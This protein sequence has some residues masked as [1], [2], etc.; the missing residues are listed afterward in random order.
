MAAL[1][2]RLSASADTL[3]ATSF[4]WW[5]PLPDTLPGAG[6]SRAS[7]SGFQTFAGNPP[8]R[9]EQGLKT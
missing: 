5:E 4:S 1:V 6:F 8:V 3:S 7:R 9:L 2:V